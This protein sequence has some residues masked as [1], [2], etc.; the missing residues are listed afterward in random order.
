MAGEAVKS[1]SVS[2]ASQ[3][4]SSVHSSGTWS[5]TSAG[6]SSAPLV[7]ITRVGGA[8]DSKAHYASYRGHPRH[9]GGKGPWKMARHRPLFRS[10]PLAQW[11]IRR[12]TARCSGEPS[13]STSV[14][15]HPQVM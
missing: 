8:K 14:V 3:V 12:T 4:G 15:F 5:G 13:T 6:K 2:V 10:H 7:Q 11:S 1:P 9:F